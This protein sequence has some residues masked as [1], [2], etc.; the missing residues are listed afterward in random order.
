MPSHAGTTVFSRRREHGVR[1]DDAQFLLVEVD[2]TLLVPAMSKLALVLLDPLPGGHGV[3]ASLR[4]GAEFM[5]NS[6]SGR[7]TGCSR[8]R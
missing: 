4:T 5:K 8:A 6:L 1:W 2:L 7:G 3:G